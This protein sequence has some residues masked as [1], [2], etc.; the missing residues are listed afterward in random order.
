MDSEAATEPAAAARDAPTPETKESWWET[1]RFFLYLFLG[2]LILRSFVFAPFNI[3]S[4]SMLPNLMI[5]DYLFV[6]KWSYGISRYSLPFGVASFQGR[7]FERLPARGDIVVF[8][9]PGDR[10]EDLVK[11]VIG[12]PGDTIEVRGG[13]VILNGRALPRRRIAD[14]E[15]PVT[16]NS[17]CRVVGDDPQARPEPGPDGP[18]CHYP[19]YVETL[20]GGRGYEVLD[21]GHSP[22]DNFPPITVPAGRLF[23]MGDNR[24]DSAD[25]RVPVFENGVGLLPIEN[26][27]GPAEWAKPWTWFTAARWRRIGHLYE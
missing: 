25:S 21:Q 11:R 20:P 27:L 24:D 8:R 2:A 16:T 17:P 14:F 15:M 9:Y 7:I 5:G 18:V 4:G 6:A 23:V 10:D 22:T 12:L 13:V 3:P 1:L 19:R 26:V